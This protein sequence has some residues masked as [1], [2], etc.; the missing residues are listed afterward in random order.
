MKVFWDKVTELIRAGFT[1]DEAIDKIYRAYGE[2]VPVS[3]ILTKMVLDRR[4]G[5]HPSLHVHAE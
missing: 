3:A 2:R 4:N 5:G 1:A